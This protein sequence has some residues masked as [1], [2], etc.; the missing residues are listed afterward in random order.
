[1]SRQPAAPPGPALSL[2]DALPSSAVTTDAAAGA[3]AGYRHGAAGWLRHVDVWRQRQA[4]ALCWF[5]R[6]GVSDRLQSVALAIRLLAL[7][8]DR[9]STR[10]NSSHV[11]ISYAGSCL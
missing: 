9:K 4:T 5:Y 10:L 7:A 8:G 3:G 1:S 2:P 11:H 6:A